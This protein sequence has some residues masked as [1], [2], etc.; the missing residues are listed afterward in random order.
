MINSNPR[1]FGRACTAAAVALATGSAGLAGG[2]V[3]AAWAGTARPP[4]PAASRPLPGLS[5][6]G[7]DRPIV[8]RR[9]F[10]IFCGDAGEVAARSRRGCTGRG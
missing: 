5:N 10:V 4:V 3:A 6:C 2:G 7:V 9:S 1:F 8:R